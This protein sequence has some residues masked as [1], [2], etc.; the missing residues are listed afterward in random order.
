MKRLCFLHATLSSFS[1]NLGILRFLY[2]MASLGNHNNNEV[3]D[4]E[5]KQNQTQDTE[6]N[7]IDY[8]KRAQWLRAALLGANDGLVSITSL[9][10]GVGAVHEDIK[11]MLL[12]GFAGLIA[13]ACSMGIGEFVSVYTQ[14]DIMVAQMKRENKIN[15]T[16]VEEEKQL[17]PNPFQAAIASAI[18][19]SFGATVPLLGAALVRDYKIRLFVVVGMASFALLVFGGVGAI[20]GKTSVKM[21]CVRVVVGG[22]MAMAI[23]F[24]LTKFV[25]Y[26]SL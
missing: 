8:S 21:S 13:G 10:L 12:A 15:S 7:N 22:W 16:F 1:F 3:N 20:L 6:E 23:T 26:S 2:F 25:G 18:A 11:T 19:F 4:I 5:A 14:F 24:G 9:I 17:L